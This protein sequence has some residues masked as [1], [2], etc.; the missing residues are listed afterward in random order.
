MKTNNAIE[1]TRWLKKGVC[2]I[3]AALTLSPAILK[4]DDPDPCGCIAQQI[5]CYDDAVNGYNQEVDSCTDVYEACGNACVIWFW[6]T[7]CHVACDLNC[8]NNCQTCLQDAS[9]RFDNWIHQ[10]DQQYDSCVRNCA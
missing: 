6:C 7:P 4:A 5:A 9:D 3:A 10:C 1:L 2:L 8:Y